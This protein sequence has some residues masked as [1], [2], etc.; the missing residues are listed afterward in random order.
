MLAANPSQFKQLE[1]SA[2]FEFLHFL[3]KLSR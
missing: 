1:V 2:A 3:R